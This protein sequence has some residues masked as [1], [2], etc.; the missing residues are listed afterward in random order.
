M[1]VTASGRSIF[2]KLARDEIHA[3]HQGKVL[4]SGMRNAEMVELLRA[5]FEKVYVLFLKIDLETQIARLHER[6][7]AMDA[8]AFDELLQLVER[9][10][11]PEGTIYSSLLDVEESADLVLDNTGLLCNFKT[12]V[13]KVLASLS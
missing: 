2:G 9:E 13:G 6:K 4:V 3:E 10:E 11:A 1:L 8:M 7:K 12:V 5:S